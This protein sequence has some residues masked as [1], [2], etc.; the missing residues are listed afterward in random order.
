MSLI[1]ADR[2]KVRSR[3]VGLDPIIIENTFPGFQN[4]DTIGDGNETYYGV[5]DNVG[6]WEI[7]RGTFDQNSQTI[8]RD[9]IVS[10][11]NNNTHVV[12]PPGGK[13]VYSTLPS[14]VVNRITAET[15]TDSFKYIS[16]ANQDTLIADSESD[17]LTLTPGRGISI[18]TNKFTDEITIG[19]VSRYVGS[20]LSESSKLL[21]DGVS[22]KI[23]GPID[24]P[25]ITSSNQPLSVT[26]DGTIQVQTEYPVYIKGAS[27]TV[28]SNTGLSVEVFPDD[29]SL[30]EV[31][32][33]KFHPDGS[34]EFPDGSI[35]TSGFSSV[36]DMSAAGNF[37]GSF[38]GNFMAADSTVLVNS[39]TSHHYGTF[40]G[41]LKDDNGD[42]IFDSETKTIHA[43]VD[44]EFYGKITDYNGTILLDSTTGK[45]YGPLVGD[46]TGSVFS[47]NGNR[48]FDAN[49]GK[50]TAEVLGNIVHPDGTILLNTT[51]KRLLARVV[52]ATGSTIVNPSTNTVSASNVSASRSLKL[53]T[54]NNVTERDLAIPIPEKGM[55]VVVG[56]TVQVFTNTWV[57]L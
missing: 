34:L 25:T 43:S 47:I 32:T 8:T 19:M 49:S 4:F 11:S 2:V 38:T 37:V 50:I 39:D 35:Q 7:G 13:T 57:S 24:S 22:G 36:F 48:A 27:V 10:S 16:V 28:R 31:A 5:F 26:A 53:P 9:N 20:V 15:L 3:F 12:F 54:Y 6:N 44:G 42:V 46:V 41:S 51:E 18:T 21:V 33:W 52:S 17:T 55:I 23:V 14:S 1:L 40:V 56:I 30:S 29:S 45:H